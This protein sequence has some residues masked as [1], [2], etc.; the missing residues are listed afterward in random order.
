MLPPSACA[1]YARLGVG[2][3]PSS[4]I[5][6]RALLLFCTLCATSVAFRFAP[7]RTPLSAKPNIGL[8]PSS[9]QT[10]VGLQKRVAVGGWQTRAMGN[11]PLRTIFGSSGGDVQEDEASPD[12]GA[13]QYRKIGIPYVCSLCMHGQFLL[14]T[15]CFDVGDMCDGS[16]RTCNYL[17]SA[18]VLLLYVRTIAAFSARFC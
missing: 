16:L 11:G 13:S 9:C 4:S 14:H 7:P 15:D 17:L 8:A 18:C 6:Q 12:R 2:V 3:P 1:C 5:M 10:H